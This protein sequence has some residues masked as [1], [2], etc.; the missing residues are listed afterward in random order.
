M[1]NIAPL[2]YERWAVL[3]SPLLIPEAERVG[4]KPP[5]RLAEP[6]DPVSAEIY[7]HG[8]VAGGRPKGPGTRSTEVPRKS[9]ERNP[10]H[11]LEGPHPTDLNLLFRVPIEILESSQDRPVVDA[12]NV[13][14]LYEHPGNPLA[15]TVR[16]SG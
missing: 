10:E 15:T 14:G 13:T 9:H 3:V 4:A 12:R 5:P 11:P 7:R 6:V 16:L 8:W 2:E 1:L